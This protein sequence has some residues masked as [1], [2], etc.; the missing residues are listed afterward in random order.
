MP[1]LILTR[2]AKSDWTDLDLSDHARPL[3]DRGQAAAP[4]IG[5]ALADRGLRPDQ[6]FCS[7][8]VRTRQT[9]AGIASALPSAPEAEIVKALY[10][11]SPDTM[12]E[13]L[14]RATGACVALISHNPGIA[15][16]ANALVAQAPAHPR[17]GHFP[18]GAT[19]IAEVEDWAS[20]RPGTAKV[21][22]FF[23]PRDLA[24]HP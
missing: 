18:T 14:H 17:F 6:V 3:N 2:H 12:L 21:V 9:W 1:T 22:D 15:M 19:L 5:Q 13:V 23:V 11:A 20:L 16:F 10:H 8:A 24:G 4:L 7:S